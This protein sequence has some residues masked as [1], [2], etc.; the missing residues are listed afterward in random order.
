MSNPYEKIFFNGS[1]AM[2]DVVV[3]LEQ[4]MV[5]ARQTGDEDMIPNLEA[6]REMAEAAGSM[7]S[8]ITIEFQ[9]ARLLAPEDTP[10]SLVTD[11]GETVH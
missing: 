9:V 3:A 5:A 10:L 8:R 1:A 11:D 2:A 7:C 4:L 6:I